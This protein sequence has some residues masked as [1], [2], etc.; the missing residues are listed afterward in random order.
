MTLIPRVTKY[1]DTNVEYNTY[2][3]MSFSRWVS[4]PDQ[5]HEPAAQVR[6]RAG[7]RS[8]LLLYVLLRDRHPRRFG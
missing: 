5:E 2:K 3:I 8:R 7:R 4:V 1:T 6:L